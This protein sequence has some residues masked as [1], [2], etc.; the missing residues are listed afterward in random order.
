MMGEENCPPCTV[1]KGRT[2]GNLS[3]KNSCTV[4]ENMLQLIQ[5]LPV[6][7]THTIGVDH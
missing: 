3:L 7:I 6:P 4:Y 1:T 5:Q 2:Q